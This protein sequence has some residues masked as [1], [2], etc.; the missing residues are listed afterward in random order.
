MITTAANTT[1]RYNWNKRGEKQG[2]EGKW[3]WWWWGQEAENGTDPEQDGEAAE[4]LTAELDPLRGGGGRSQSVWTIPGQ[5]L[6]C[7]GV[8]QALEDKTEGLPPSS[9]D[10]T[11]KSPNFFSYYY[12][13]PRWTTAD[14]NE[15]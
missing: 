9:N 13:G 2:H 3:W 10:K 1:P 11:E 6:D 5:N 12:S 15:F 8:G 4:Q 7:S 14:H